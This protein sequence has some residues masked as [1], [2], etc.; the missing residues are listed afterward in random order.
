MPALGV[1]DLDHPE[2]GVDTQGA[3]YVGIEVRLGLRFYRLHP[4]PL[5]VA[6]R[7]LAVELGRAGPPVHG[8]D[9][10]RAGPRIALARHRREGAALF[11]PADEGADPDVAR[12]K[13]GVSANRTE[14]RGS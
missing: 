9:Q 13:Q 7:G 8:F 2:V 1:L 11:G 10:H 14:T 3:L 6:A 4:H 12:K 5:A